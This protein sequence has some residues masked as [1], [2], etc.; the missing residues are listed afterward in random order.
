VSTALVGI[1]AVALYYWSRSADPLIATISR[2]PQTELLLACTGIFGWLLG[3]AQSTLLKDWV[4]SSEQWIP[5]VIV[6]AIGAQLCLMTVPAGG[7]YLALCLAGLVPW[8]TLRRWVNRG[9][10]WITIHLTAAIA[11]AVTIPVMAAIITTFEWGRGLAFDLNVDYGSAV[12]ISLLWL[13]YSASSALAMGKL[14]YCPRS[15]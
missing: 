5:T 3:W 13:I 15:L 14:F 4:T 2:L 7:L 9:Y 8:L 12:N 10:L 1:G 11:A 6:G